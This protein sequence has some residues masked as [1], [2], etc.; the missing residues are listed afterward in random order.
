MAW[1]IPRRRK[2]YLAILLTASV[3]AAIAGFRRSEPGEPRLSYEQQCRAHCGALSSQVK[4]T[5]IDPM[6][7]ESRRNMP[8]SIECLCGSATSGKRL[9]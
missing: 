1:N 7:P 3:A 2:V 4:K 5:Y 8:R 6:S 9:F